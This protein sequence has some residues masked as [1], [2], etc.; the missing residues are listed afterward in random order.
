MKLKKNNLI[1]HLCAFSTVD[2]HIHCVANAFRPLPDNA[3]IFPC[4]T[5]YS[6]VHVWYDAMQRVNVVHKL[7]KAAQF[8]MWHQNLEKK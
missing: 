2:H 1:L 8:N 5:L 7:T 6:A 4:H 3:E